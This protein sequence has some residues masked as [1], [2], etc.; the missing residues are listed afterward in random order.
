MTQQHSGI[1]KYG[2]GDDTEK[3]PIPVSKPKQEPMKGV[4]SSFTSL[5]V[6]FGIAVIRPFHAAAASAAVMQK[7]DDVGRRCGRLFC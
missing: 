5:S 1:N 7:E 2:Y 4:V 3:S 6:I